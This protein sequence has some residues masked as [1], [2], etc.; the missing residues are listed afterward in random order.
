M[1]RLII[2]SNR[3][4]APTADDTPAAG[5]LAI[6]LESALK[7]RGGFWLGW[8]GEIAEDNALNSPRYLKANNL[9]YILLDLT[10]KQINQYYYGFSNR[11]LWPLCHYRIDLMRYEEEDFKGYIKVNRLFASQLQRL[12][13]PEDIVWVHDYHLM[14][15]ASELR[16]AGLQNALGFFMHTPFPCPDVFFTAPPCLELLQV[17]CA[18]DLLGFQS[19]NDLQNFKSCLLDSNIATEIAHNHYRGRGH[20]FKVGV[21]SASI[22]S[23]GFAKLASKSI[24]PKLDKRLIVGVDRLDYSKGLLEKMQAYKLFLKQHAGFSEKVKFLQITPRSRS[25]VPEYKCLHQEAA[26][27]AGNINGQYG[28]INW[29]P[30][31][32][33]NKALDHSLL[34]SIYRDASVG[35]VTPLRDGMNL[36]AKEYI[37]AQNPE[38][39]GV[40]ILS[41]F[42]GAADELTGVLL[43]NPYDKQNVA[44]AI[45]TALTMPKDERYAR[46]QPMQS[47]LLKYDAVKWCDSFLA[48][49]SSK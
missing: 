39:P 46:W 47:Y 31:N 7:N 42:A 28:T 32:Y 15:L 12:L 10:K 43:V 45:A 16:Q 20:E 40:L 19:D 3:V 38:N 13:E 4:A 29:T 35:L 48:Q 14:P 17:M 24:T 36:V 26:K 27:L 5:G 9:E 1:S 25:D 23:A 21:F 2:V 33:I 49:L 41:C 8:S 6:A 18:Y 37:A 34:S 30:I 44:N 22:D 11:L